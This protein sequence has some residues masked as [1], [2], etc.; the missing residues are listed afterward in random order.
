MTSR[1]L[2]LFTLAL[3]C[4]ALIAC[5]PA[6]TPAEK[7]AAAPDP[8]PISALRDQVT[9]A[10]N[11]GNAAEVANLYTDDAIVMAAHEPAVEGK[12]AIQASL[13]AF[14]QNN[15]A[16][17]T[18]TAQETQIAGDWAY[19]RGAASMT[20]T[21]KAGGKPIADSGKYLTILKRLPGGSWKVHRGMDNSN[22]PLPM[23]PGRKK[24]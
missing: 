21:P 1:K 3:V 10:Y 12:Q 18:L 24:K 13:Q 15:T 9:A 4:I 22:N 5:Q 20:V 2:G 23:P 11:A 16:R 7:A 6:S 19:D 8:A 17:M 14:F